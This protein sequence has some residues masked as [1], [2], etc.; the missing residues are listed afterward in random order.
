[1]YFCCAEVSRAA[2]DP[3]TIELALV[4]DDLVLRVVG[5]PGE[6]IDL[7][8]I[9]DRIEAA[10]GQLTE[11]AGRLRVTVPVAAPGTPAT[12]GAGQGPGV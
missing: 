12:S 9:T 2:D 5:V 3:Q 7:Q 6:G 11:E 1:M 8:G 10:G 4:D